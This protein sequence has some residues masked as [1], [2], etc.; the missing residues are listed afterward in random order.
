MGDENL[1]NLVD[2][3]HREKIVSLRSYASSYKLIADFVR[4]KNKT[5]PSLKICIAGSEALGDDVR[6]AVQEYMNCDIISQYADEECGILRQEAI[7]GEPDR[8]YLNHASYKF[9]VLKMN[10]NEPADYGELGRI[11]I[12][13]LTNRAF[14][15]IRYDTGDIA[16]MERAD[17]LSAGYPYF[18]ALYGRRLDLIYNVNGEPVHPMVLNR[19]M[20]N[21][22][23]IIQWQFIQKSEKGY[24]LK[25]N[26]SGEVDEDGII[27]EL[28]KYFGN[29]AK[30]DIEYVSD[31]PV[32]KSGKRKSVVNEWKN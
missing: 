13:D 20:K 18:S 29:E 22:G 8:F 10:S 1:E 28:R 30:I 6:S 31:I 27:Q 26:V 24:A 11:V 23:N 5:L 4:R 21:F 9:E 16:V 25:L 12:T 7:S 32:L 19:V 17:H 14:P 2:I 15:I 3:I